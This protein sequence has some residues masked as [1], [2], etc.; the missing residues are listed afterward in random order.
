MSPAPFRTAVLLRSEQ[1]GG[2]ISVIENTVP[3]GWEGPPLH[4]HDFD[5]TFCVLD[6]ELTFQ[7]G[8]EQATAAQGALAF[9]RRGDHHTLANLTDADARYLLVCTPGGFERYFDRIAAEQAGVEPPAT[10]SKP[11]PETMVVGPRIGAQDARATSLPV[12]QGAINVLLRSEQ[13]DAQV[14]IM[15]NIVPADAKGPPLHTHDFDE[16]FYIVGGELT[17]QVSDQLITARRGELAFAPRG[18]PHAFTNRSGEAARF[19]LVCTPAGFERH[20]ARLAAQQAGVEPPAW[21]LQPIPEVTR[22][23]P[24]IGE[25]K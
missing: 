8:D 11:Y 14:S 10:A 18:V 20:F 16:S 6:G 9:A 21:A 25:A 5:E 2:A 1:T 4:R 23:G 24:R 3:A 22:V 12:P 15:D 7:V 17:F 19:V 13:T